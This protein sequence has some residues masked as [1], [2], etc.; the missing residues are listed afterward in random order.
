MRGSLK[1]PPKSNLDQQK[2][3][4]QK[5]NTRRVQDQISSDAE[6]SVPEW[7]GYVTN[8][9]QKQSEKIRRLWVKKHRHSENRFNP[10]TTGNPFLGTKLLGFGIRRGLGALKGL[11]CCLAVIVARVGWWW[12]GG[13]T[14]NKTDQ[15]ITG[16]SSVQKARDP[17]GGGQKNLCWSGWRR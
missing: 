14:Q 5:L 4:K 2:N 13:E 3:T 6:K 17:R 12:W 11:K 8:L 15:K 1:V 9:E 16:H 7:P 10:F